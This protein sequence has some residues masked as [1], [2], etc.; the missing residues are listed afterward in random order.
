VYI[1]INNCIS[2][3]VGIDERDSGLQF[4]WNRLR[5]GKARTV[6]NDVGEKNL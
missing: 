3:A 5:A 6:L 4:N 2:A 1:F